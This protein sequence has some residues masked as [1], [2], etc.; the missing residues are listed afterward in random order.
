MSSVNCWNSRTSRES[1]IGLLQVSLVAMSTRR[2]TDMA[3][4]IQYPASMS[5]V[6]NETQVDVLGTWLLSQTDELSAQQLLVL[7]HKRYFMLLLIAYSLVVKVTLH[8]TRGMKLSGADCCVTKTWS[9]LSDTRS[10]PSQHI[11]IYPAVHGKV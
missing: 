1:R 10:S 5:S 7:P 4:S 11:I 2:R 6:M 8:G 3:V 9:S